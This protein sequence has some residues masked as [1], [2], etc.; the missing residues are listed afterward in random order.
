M[1]FFDFDENI[2]KISNQALELCSQEFKN[3]E[4]ICE[5][6]SQKVLKEFINCKI[7]ESHFNFTTGYGYSDRGRE[8]LDELFARIFRAEDALVRLG[9]TSGTHALCTALFG[10]LRP[11]D[12][13]LSLTGDLYDTMHK[14]IDSDN[15]N[16]GSLK[17]FNINFEYLNYDKNIFENIKNKLSKNNFKAVYIQKSRGYSLRESLSCENI[18]ELIDFVKNI[19]RNVIVIVDNCYGEFV[20]K[21]EPSEYG[22]DLTVGS[23]IKNLGGGIAPSGGYIVGK[24][25]YVELCAHR[26]VAPGLGKE[27]GSNPFGYRELFM[28]IFNAPKI[29][30]EALKTAVFCASVFEILKFEVSPKFNQKRYDIVQSIVLKKPENMISFCRGIQNC[31]PIDSFVTPEPWDMPGYNHQVIMAAGNFISGSSIELSADGPLKE[32][33]VIWLQG[34]T[35]FNMSKIGILQSINNILFN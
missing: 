26:F 12:K 3:I 17:D 21:L 16:L 13:I 25:E 19:N 15:L 5:F 35:N 14:I 27:I 18:K 11:G 28:G 4:E 24:R 30:A 9:F 8:K 29:V 23:L 2:I 1:S 22:A 33:Y 7:S 6:N 32:P 20:E 31:S 10:I 34:G